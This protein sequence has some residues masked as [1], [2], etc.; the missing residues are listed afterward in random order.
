[1]ITRG[2]MW[3]II[4]L[5]LVLVGAAGCGKFAQ[6]KAER[7]FPPV[8]KF[9][10]VEGLK[11]H[12]IEKGEGV[13]V[14]LMHGASGNVRD[15]QLSIFDQVAAKHRAIAFDRPGHG[16]SERPA[17]KG[18]DPR[19]QARI[20]HAAMEKLGIKKPVLVGHSWSGALV[21]A[22]ALQYPDDVGSILFL[23]GVSHPW[24]GGVG[25]NAEIAS[26][27]VV[28]PLFANTLV[29]VAA[30]FVIDDAIAA[31]FDPNPVP[32]GY[33]ENV[34]IALFLRPANYLA[35]AEDLTGL[36]KAVAEMAPLY[37]Q[38]TAPLIIMTGDSDNTIWPHIHSKKLKEKLPNAEYIV[39]KNTG[40]MP[41][42]ARPDEVLAA[43]DRLAALQN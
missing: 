40:H 1:M 39:L 22:Y 9:V 31:N 7:D 38:I 28:G 43:I 23:S 41:H 25:L 18:Y 20:I 16:Y 36:K 27:P 26:K 6:Q 37:S 21:L 8:G 15:W 24:P 4:V 12:Y 10:E 30:P 35:N 19:V 11:L 14:L 42:H 32:E 33:A 29:P 17:E 13:P 3:T 2:F 34:G 5:I